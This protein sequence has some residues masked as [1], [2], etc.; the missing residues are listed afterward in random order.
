MGRLVSSGGYK[1]YWRADDRDRPFFNP[2]DAGAPMVALVEYF[3]LADQA[4]QVRILD[5]LRRSF[6]FEVSV[7]H[8]VPN[9]FGLARQ[10][11][12]NKQG[13]RRT[14]F[15]YPHDSDTSPWWQ[16]ENARLA[17]LAAA[18]RLAAPLFADDPSFQAQLQGYALDQ[19][20]WILGLN[21]FDA[22]ML[23][24][25]G[26]NNPEYRFFT[27]WEYKSA[28]GGI[29]NGITSGYQDDEGIDLNVPY[30]V[31][32]QDSDWRWAEQWLPHAAWYM[33]A[34]AA[35]KTSAPP[36][37]EAVIAYIFVQDHVIDPAPIAAEKL[38]HINYAFAN[39]KDGVIV[40]GFKNDARNFQALNSLKA[41]NPKL[42]VL[43]SVG[44][45]TWSG[46]FSDVALTKDSRR[47]FVDSTVAFLERYKLDGLDVD[48]EFPGQEGLHN[49]N[50]PQDKE[51]CTAL[52]ADL[53]AALDKAGQKAGKRF[54][55][56]MAVQAADEWL[57]HTEM[58]KVAESL[59]F[60]NLMAY[61]QFEPDGD[62]ITGHHAPLFTHPA[63]PKHLSAA[64]A[65]SHFIAAGVPPAKI[66]L[67]VPFYGH[68]WGQV[69]ATEHGL[70]QPG[71]DTKQRIAES[72]EMID[73]LENKDGFVHYWD[74]ISKA[75][76][77]YNADKLLFISYDDQESIR[78]KGR[79]VSDRGLG[80]VMFWEYS[81]DPKNK[82]L[83]AI[84]AGLTQ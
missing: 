15:F 27:S 79:Y 66:V 45:W 77:L 23:E 17:S 51:N 59:D 68:A 42:K 76:F 41:R 49:V 35:G 6:Q 36:A 71:K 11:V 9:P 75:P 5:T 64:I 24:G 53:R 81:G 30:E 61:D 19:L 4:G 3:K 25:A 40:E 54:L 34:T 80:G 74:D 48:W 52:M 14:S 16:G 70:Y 28:P 84:H 12:Q 67:G 56:T 50:R 72:F 46:Q 60:A 22:S 57:E 69:P 18:A 26:R 37:Q 8:E 21:P 43:V 7:T 33:L 10:Y 55:L 82:L 83:D 39:I 78:L 63:N 13:R 44:G 73:K 20:N 38:T 29:C 1:D 32:H 58:G 65:V 2:S 31:T 47:K 62:A